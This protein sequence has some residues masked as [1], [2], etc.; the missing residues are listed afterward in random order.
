VIYQRVDIEDCSSELGMA[1][2]SQLNQL[3]VICERQG[4]E[5]GKT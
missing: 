3:P 5:A 2:Q 1:D 4:F